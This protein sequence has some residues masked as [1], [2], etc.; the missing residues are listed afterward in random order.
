MSVGGMLRDYRRAID[1]ASDG[2]IRKIPSA[3][4]SVLKARV[5]YDIGPRFHSLYDLSRRSEAGWSEYIIDIGLKKYLRKINNEEDRSVVGDK[6]EFLRHCQRFDLATIPIISTIDIKDRKDSL[7]GIE[8][9]NWVSLLSNAPSEIF[10][11]LVDGTW[12]ID[13]FV[14][15]R[16]EAGVWYYCGEHGALSDL[17][18]FCMQRLRGR[19][20]WIVQP[21][22]KNAPELLR[23]MSPS[24][25]GTVRAVTMLIDGVPELLVAVLR[26]PVGSNRADNFAHGSS[27]NLTAPIDLQTGGVGMARGSRSRTWPAMVDVPRHPDTGVLIPGSVL[28]FWAELVQL[29]LHA[30]RTLPHLSTLGWDV[31]ITEHGPII[32]EANSTYDMDL[33]QVAHGRGFKTELVKKRLELHP[34]I[35]GSR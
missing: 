32:V 28:P 16:D 18:D 5:M 23:I 9:E 31:A 24:A 3:V 29:V 22:V 20:G 15:E 35:Q 19:R 27:G 10:I 13:A 11:K 30:Q 2:S 17:H 1:A 8:L 14:A 34:A 26:L 33:I 6:L 12:G 4:Y 7:N 25:L 21:V